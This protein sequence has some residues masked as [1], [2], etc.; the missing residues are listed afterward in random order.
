MKSQEK[1]VINNIYM[2]IEIGME[3]VILTCNIEKTAS[4]K[5]IEK[6]YAKT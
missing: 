2:A 1:Y 3:D 6:T 4:K 5:I